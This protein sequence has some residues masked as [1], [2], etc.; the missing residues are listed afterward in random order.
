LDGV[1]YDKL[2]TIPADGADHKVWYKITVSNLGAVKLNDIAVVEM[3]DP[4]IQACIDTQIPAAL[5]VG[6]SKDIIC[7]TSLNCSNIPN[8]VLENTVEVYGKVAVE[9]EDVCAYNKDGKVIADKSQCSATVKCETACVTRTP[10]YWFTHWKADGEFCATLETAIKLNGDK[11]DL[12]FMCLSGT[13]SEVLSKAL[14]IFWSKRNQ[15]SDGRGS[16]LC[17]ARKQLG[18]HLIAA[19]ANV[20][21]LGT[22]PAGCYYND[23]AGKPVFFPATLISDAQK[24]AACGDLGEIRK[25]TGLLDKFNNSGDDADFPAGWYPCKADPRG[26]KAAMMDPTTKA[27][28]DD[29]S[30][31][32]AGKACK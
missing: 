2:V 7:E 32:A 4:D 3:T 15:T 24:A 28:C 19:I 25:M 31:C 21:L 11:L 10:G 17:R 1:T 5:A 9:T 20:Q 8:G 14:G 23:D 30:N 26:A 18:F 16:A 6:E 12:G 13:R 22:N 27:S 29:L